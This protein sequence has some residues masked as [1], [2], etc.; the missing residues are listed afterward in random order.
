MRDVESDTE[1][2]F[3]AR[4]QPARL[5]AAPLEHDGPRRVRDEAVLLSRDIQLHDVAS[6]QAARAGNPVHDLIVTLTRTVPGSLR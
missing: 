5:L 6:L 1:R 2:F 4:R 3:G